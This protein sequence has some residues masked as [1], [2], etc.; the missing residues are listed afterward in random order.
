[1]GL[2]VLDGPCL[3]EEASMIN[4]VGISFLKCGMGGVANLALELL[5]LL[6]EYVSGQGEVGSW[7]KW[8]KC[9]TVLRCE[10]AS[11]MVGWHWAAYFL[12]A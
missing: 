7:D 5:I 10:D 3:V 1:M 9:P 6:G 2:R 12:S 4:S 11:R 8:R